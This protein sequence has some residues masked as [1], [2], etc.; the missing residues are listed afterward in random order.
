MARKDPLISVGDKFIVTTQE[1]KRNAEIIESLDEWIFN[2]KFSYDGR[3]WLAPV[4]KNKIIASY[5]DTWKPIKENP[6]TL[7][8][9]CVSVNP[10]PETALETMETTIKPEITHNPRPPVWEDKTFVVTKGIGGIIYFGYKCPPGEL[11]TKKAKKEA[12]RKLY[13]AFSKFVKKYNLKPVG[14]LSEQRKE[15]NVAAGTKKLRMKLKRTSKLPNPKPPAHQNP[16]ARESTAKNPAAVNFTEADDR[17]ARKIFKKFTGRAPDK[18]RIFTLEDRT[19]LV[20]LGLA[21]SVTYEA[22][23][24]GAGMMRYIHDITDPDAKLYWDLQNNCL[25]IFGHNL[26]VTKAGIE[27]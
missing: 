15:A 11:K 14:S 6:C 18:L 10:E 26:E 1:G 20:E 21:Y 17:A 19:I 2:V 8:N 4:H 16:P 7:E 12:A 22:E 5:K 13:N 25:V 23:K 3:T 24:H 9:P 27:G